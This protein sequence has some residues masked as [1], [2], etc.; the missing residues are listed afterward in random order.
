MAIAHQPA[1]TPDPA[2]ARP[3]LRRSPRAPVPVDLRSRGWTAAHLAG[4]VAGTA[5]CAALA[6]AVV[7]GS[8]LFALLNFG[9]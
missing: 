3:E 8:L 2:S 9:G 4:L 1:T 7:V 6:T 5:L